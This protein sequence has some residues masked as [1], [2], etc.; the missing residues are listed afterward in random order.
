MGGPEKDRGHGPLG[1]LS[2]LDLQEYHGWG[3]RYGNRR[4]V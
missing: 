1:T 2:T 4:L 3:E